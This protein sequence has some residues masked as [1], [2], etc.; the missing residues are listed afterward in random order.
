MTGEGHTHGHHGRTGDYRKVVA[1]QA[2]FG[3]TRQAD[4]QRHY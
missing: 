3:E 4:Q 1:D 2:S